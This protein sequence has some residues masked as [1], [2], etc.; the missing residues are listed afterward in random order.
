MEA[1]DRSNNR[2]Q[3]VL[4]RYERNQSFLDPDPT[5]CG[6]TGRRRKPL[7]YRLAV[8]PD[9]ALLCLLVQM[10][11]ELNQQI[12]MLINRQII[13]PIVLFL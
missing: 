5:E 4:N 1:E 2:L 13:R 6:S 8:W 12:P 7:F 3:C 11:E 10:K 9:A